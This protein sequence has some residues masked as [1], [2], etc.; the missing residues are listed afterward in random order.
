MATDMNLD[1]L[2]TILLPQLE[3]LKNFNFSFRNPLFW[4]FLFLLFLVLTR[5]WDVRK[6]FSFCLIVG[7]LLLLSTELGWYIGVLFGNAPFAL[8]L[9]KLFSLFVIAIIFL[10]YALIK[11]S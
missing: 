11:D 1:T 6:S 4:V 10:Y 8:F 9:V 7:I 3:A 5:F 2:K